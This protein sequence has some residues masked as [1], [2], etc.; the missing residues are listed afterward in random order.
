MGGE[1]RIFGE[2]SLKLALVPAKHPQCVLIPLQ[3]SGRL[4]FAQRPPCRV[5]RKQLFEA[6]AFQAEAVQLLGKF[7][8]HNNKSYLQHGFP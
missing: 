3:G 1:D 6:L 8:V 5:V 2:F 7:T 4:D